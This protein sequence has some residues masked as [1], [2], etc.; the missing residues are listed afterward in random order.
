MAVHEGK[1]G[2]TISRRDSSRSAERKDKRSRRGRELNNG[3][4]RGTMLG[5]CSNGEMCQRRCSNGG[6]GVEGSEVEG[7]G[8]WGF[9]EQR[10]KNERVHSGTRVSS[11]FNLLSFLTSVI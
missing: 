3:G 6:L 5:R 4:L 8:V 2:E 9:T 7:L 1:N 11:I 10:A